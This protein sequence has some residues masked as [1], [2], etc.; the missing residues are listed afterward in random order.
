MAH[1]EVRGGLGDL[2]S[3]TVAALTI[4]PDE[5]ADRLRAAGF[6]PQLPAS[7]F[8]PPPQPTD[9]ARWRPA[10]EAA[11]AAGR[12]LTIRY[13]TAGRNVLT[14]RTVTPISRLP[15][16]MRDHLARRHCPIPVVVCTPTPL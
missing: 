1:P 9:P 14:E 12:S 11:S 3:P 15:S 4:P 5:L 13:F 8:Q 10:I 2:L 16:A 7:S 6:F